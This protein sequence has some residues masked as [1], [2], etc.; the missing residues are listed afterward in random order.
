MK[1]APYL[2]NLCRCVLVLSVL[3]GHLNSSALGN[4]I[5][6]SVPDS[7]M[8]AALHTDHIERERGVGAVAGYVINHWH[9]STLEQLVHSEV[10]YNV[11][12]SL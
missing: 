11:M 8:A 2:Y 7:L 9:S 12:D 5:Q 3:T 10:T 6:Q 1:R 4:M